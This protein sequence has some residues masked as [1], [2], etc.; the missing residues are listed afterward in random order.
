MRA[1]EAVEDFRGVEVEPR[2]FTVVLV[3]FCRLTLEDRLPLPVRAEAV[4]A[5]SEPNFPERAGKAAKYCSA[6]SRVVG[7]CGGFSHETVLAE[8]VGVAETVAPSPIS[9]LSERW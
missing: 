2:G 5:E 9:S 7:A 8:V 6:C 4:A 1:S 3:T